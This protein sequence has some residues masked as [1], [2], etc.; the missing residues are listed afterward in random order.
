MQDLQTA[1][2]VPRTS[3]PRAIARWMVT[4][5]GF[6][7][8]GLATLI[9]GP[10][11]TLGAALAGGL[12]TGAV[13]G[14]FGGNRPPA[15]SWIVATALG[16]MTGL[17]LGASAVD[18]ETTL[19]ALVVQG[20]LS[21]LLVGAAQGLVLLPRLG[22]LSLAWAPALSAIWSAGWAVTT[23]AG[24]DVDQRF[25]VFGSSGA[26]LVTALTAALPLALNRIAEVAS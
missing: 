19:G 14:G 8:A 24:I 4:F 11:D 16:L 10:V 22:P 3:S 18:Y 9:T 2:A 6:P 12:L 23:G 5:L 17:A 7:L 21:G 13:L 25:T 15:A 1:P 26:L 20:A